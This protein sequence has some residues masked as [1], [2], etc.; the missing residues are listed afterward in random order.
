MTTAFKNTP[1]EAKTTD[2]ARAMV[3]ALKDARAYYRRHGHKTQDIAVG[4]Y[5]DQIRIADDNGAYD[6]HR[7]PHG[8]HAT[9]VGAVSTTLQ[10]IATLAVREINDRAYD[11]ATRN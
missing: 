11:E 9:S 1:A 2:A 6:L 5:E 3:A 10:S 7:G 8:W 4:A